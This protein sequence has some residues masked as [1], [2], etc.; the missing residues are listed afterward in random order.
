LSF[1]V[2]SVALTGTAFAQ[3]TVVQQWSVGTL[4][5]G[6]IAY[7]MDRDHVFMVT[8]SSNEFHE[9]DRFGTFINMWSGAGAQCNWPVGLDIHDGTH[10]LW[11]A[12]EYTPEKV[13]ECTRDGVFV[14]SFS[15]DAEMSDA[16][17]IAYVDSRDQLYVCDDT[18]GVNEVVIWTPTGSLVGRWS[19]APNGDT[20]SIAYL[21]ATDTL[22]IGDDNGAVVYE[23][24]L[25]GVLLNTYD[26]AALLGINGV[27]GL[28]Y[29]PATGNV[30]LGDSTTGARNIYEIA[31]FVQATPVE[32]TSWGSIKA[33]FK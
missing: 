27:E 30:F 23:W 24:T 22:L 6:G 14:S 28:S 19:T 13:V 26:M 2:L 15:V 4:F 10:N 11:V 1:V 25:D 7:D 21:D 20:D 5:P 17:G 3:L 31:G 16:V 8:N 18:P 32:Q 29:D 33:A 9:F 12:D